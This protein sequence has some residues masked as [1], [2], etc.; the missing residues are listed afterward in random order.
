MSKDNHLVYREC[1]A[2]WDPLLHP[3]VQKANELDATIVQIKEKFGRLRVYFDPGQADTDALE[4]MIDQ[5]ELESG[6]TCELCGKPGKGM[7]SG[8]SWHKTLCAEHG[9]E[10]GYKQA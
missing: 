7:I 2:G 9:I 3:I 4:E 6:K 8:G 1:G 5:A 10:L